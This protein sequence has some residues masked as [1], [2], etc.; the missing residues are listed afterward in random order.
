MA[1][2]GTPSDRHDSQAMQALSK[3]LERLRD[4]KVRRSEPQGASGGGSEREFPSLFATVR[5]EVAA[6]RLGVTRDEPAIAE[7]PR[8]HVDPLS[9]PRPMG[10][11][12]GIEVR[13]EYEL[14]E[15]LAYN[16]EDFLHAAY[17]S[18]LGREPDQGALTH[19][20]GLLYRGETSKIGILDFLAGSSEAKTRAARVR[21]LAR[22]LRFHRWR[23]LPIVGR[24]LGYGKALIDLRRI[25]AITERHETLHFRHEQDLLGAIDA[26]NALSDQSRSAVE[27][28]GR[29]V[30]RLEREKAARDVALA[31]TGKVAALEANAK[32]TIAELALRPTHHELERVGRSIVAAL[33]ELHSE[34]AQIDRRKSE[35]EAVTAGL[36]EALRRCDE[37]A[38]SKIDGTE[39]EKRIDERMARG[40]LETMGDEDPHLDSFYTQFEDRFRG[41]RE[42]IRERV[43][44]YLPILTEAA[45]GSKEAPVLDVGCG[46]GE[47]LELIRDAGLVGRGVDLNVE[48]VA[49][50]R[51][52]DLEVTQGNAIAHL[53]ALKE[54]SIGAIV[55]LHLIEHL[56]FRRRI[57]LLDAALRALKPGGALVLETP[58]PENIN[59]GAC[60]FWNDPSHIQPLPPE[61]TQAIVELRGF[62]RVEIVRLHAY[63]FENHLPGA[64]GAVRDT[65]NHLIYGPRDYAIVGYKPRPDVA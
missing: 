7:P 56:P 55:A 28:L 14:G 52:L 60:T 59:V 29:E 61:S 9:P 3:E 12:D 41:T 4:D 33:S 21:G 58:N 32:R 8:V 36:R 45:A 1:D 65:L 64:G 23:R 54:G 34:L 10:S 44:I 6:R 31:L 51:G 49:I 53:R 38:A 22:V 48:M 62:D 30:V 35:V 63:P 37:L 11:P 43:G 50:C 16:G 25:S 2:P 39:I 46:R 27:H 19:F 20:I 42:E 26:L 24:L 18:L 47:L 15:L 57:A 40:G 17:W 5:A 13:K